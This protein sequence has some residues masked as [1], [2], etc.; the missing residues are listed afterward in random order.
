MSEI[1]AYDVFI[2]YVGSDRAWVE[3]FLLDALEKA[4][5]K[6][7][8]EEAFRLGVP[9]IQEFQRAIQKSR[10]TLLAISQAYLADDLSEFVELLGLSYGQDTQ[11][12]P[13][14]PLLLEPV[15]LPP[16]LAML[17]RLNA[18]T[19]SDQEAAVNR[20]CA[21]L[22]HPI[23]QESTKPAC[24]YPGMKPFTEDNSRFFYGREQEINRLRLRLRKQKYF[25]IIGTSGSGKSSFIFAGL[26][27]EL[28]KTQPGQWLVKSL[29]PGQTA[30][31]TPMQKLAK[32]L[33]GE[34][35]KDS[36]TV[37]QY[38]QLIDSILV[39]ENSE[40][41]ILLIIDQF[42]ELFS[43]STTTEQRQLFITAI[44]FLRRVER[45]SSILSMRADFYPDLMN[46]ELWPLQGVERIEI[47]PLRGERLRE[48]IVNPAENSGVYIEGKLVERLLI[49]AANE[50]GAMPLLQETML[51]LW[52]KLERRFLPLNAYEK[53]GGLQTA[54]ALSAD[55][56]LANLETEEKQAIARRIFLRLIQFGEGRPDTRRQQLEENLQSV[57]DNLNVFRQTLDHIETHRLL[58]F[59]GEEST[60]QRKVDIAHEALIAG[61]PTLQQ[62][63]K[64]RRDAEGIRRRLENKAQEWVDRGKGKGGL[65]D[66]VEL[67]EAERW[68][69]SLDAKELG[70]PKNLPDLVKAS[71]NAIEAAQ[72]EKEAIHQRELEQA[73]KLEL[74]LANANEQLSIS[75]SQRL[76]FASLLTTSEPETALLLACEAVRWNSNQL[77]GDALRDALD[78]VTWQVREFT[79]HV[80][81]VNSAVF[82]RDGK[83]I[84]TASDDRTARLW[85]ITGRCIVICHD[86][87]D[88]VTSAV[89]SPDERQILTTSVDGLLRLWNLDGQLIRTLSCPSRETAYWITGT[90]SPDGRYILVC[91]E[92]NAWLLDTNGKLQS[93]NWDASSQ[94]KADMKTWMQDPSSYDDPDERV[95]SGHTCRI[96]S[97]V[98]SPDGQKI[99]TASEDKTARIWDISGQQFAVLHGHQYQVVNAIFVPPDGQL[100]LTGSID[101][102]ARLW[103]RDGE[104]VAI[105]G[106]HSG[107]IGHLAFSPDGQLIL[108]AADTRSDRENL[109]RLWDR[110]GHLLKTFE[111]HK[112]S[113]V[114]KQVVFSP[115]GQRIVT[116]SHIGIIRLWDLEGRI[117]EVFQGHLGRINSVAFSPT[118]QSILTASNDGTAR[119][120]ESARSVL[121]TIESRGIIAS[122]IYNSDGTHILTSTQDAGGR[123]CLW[124]AS[125]Q[126]R[127]S[128]Q[129]YSNL[130]T[131][132]VLSSDGRYLLT[133]QR[134]LEQ[135]NLWQLPPDLQSFN[136]RIRSEGHENPTNHVESPFTLTDSDSSRASLPSVT[137]SI[138]AEH[139]TKGISNIEKAI[140]S[141]DCRHILILAGGSLHLWTCQGELV[142]VL[143]GPNLYRRS[144]GEPTVDFAMFS[145][146]SLLVLSGSESGTVWL[147]GINGQL[148]TSFLP[149]GSYASDNL[150]SLAFSPNG[151]RI[152]TTIRHSADLWDL[153]GQ[154]LAKLPCEIHKPRRVLF[155]P[156][157]DRIVT[158]GE[159]ASPDIRLW[160][161]DGRLITQLSANYGEFGPVLF[162][163]EGNYLCIVDRNI[164]QLWDCDGSQVARLVMSRDDR[165]KNV[166]FSPDGA[167]LLVAFFNGLVQL[168]SLAYGGKLLSTFKGHTAEVNSAVFSP[169][170]KRILTAS[171]D[172]TARQFLVQVE[173]LLAVAARR[174][175]RSLNKEEIAR[176][177]VQMPLKFDPKD[178]RRIEALNR[179]T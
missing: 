101:Q 45:I 115:D 117:L 167:K 27:P 20:L 54:I 31:E 89:F 148:V 98:F 170:G 78:K 103:T 65:L 36:L 52:D 147:W 8:L 19:P 79:D 106:G 124:Y 139:T 69:S 107:D 160:D 173:D 176:F 28:Q 87:S 96:Y 161:S 163:R 178:L 40:T 155:S 166:T 35:L 130:L 144:K 122:A 177:N 111:G 119:L 110:S 109:L 15:L 102:T 129:G 169:D 140:F 80:G 142:A 34:N 42:E 112:N 64:G 83:Q 95:Y 43:P 116:T 143:K 71:R 4:E 75:E 1:F 29:R 153:N 51:L 172:G 156:K 22:Q 59:S 88:R 151:Q 121:P 2:S 6:Y 33:G 37:E 175:D 50:P 62:W 108:T 67:A 26:V 162:D 113:E 11:T 25:C 46:S 171:S 131:N 12:W 133:V 23:P 76:A 165:I 157:G 114:I 32:V 91:D 47:V 56:A 123:T 132:E 100:I 66:E 55:A 68:L 150:F 30:N 127:T 84:L 136:T 81:A 179:T 85:D 141:P 3:G 38:S 10:R 159:A 149:D 14:I 82:S 7:I 77:S 174:I 72:Q 125:G 58:T 53:T 120:W 18:T 126:L 104:L 154:H 57:G 118:G 97:A 137:F 17:V 74:A 134:E 44:K 145:P 105:L 152:L 128:Y 5:V 135:V 92:G 13:V 146:D 41:Q 138:S 164:I 90:F 168:W 93:T 49:D 94:Y 21:D 63:I 16:R 61:W 158:V 60:Q 70:V 86:H 39:Q 24:P 9:R 73:K 99:L 48:A